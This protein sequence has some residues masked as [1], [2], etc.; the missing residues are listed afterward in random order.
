[1]RLP[2]RTSNILGRG[3]L[4]V[5]AGGMILHVIILDTRPDHP[6]DK[7]CAELWNAPANQAN[8][9]MVRRP[10]ILA[11]ECLGRRTQQGRADGLHGAVAGARGWTLD[12]DRRRPHR[13]L[14]GLGRRRVRRSVRD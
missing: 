7:R 6:D 5:L 9:S 13:D 11:G 2:Q 12:P 4:G 8:R 1:M 10:R 14:G 3:A